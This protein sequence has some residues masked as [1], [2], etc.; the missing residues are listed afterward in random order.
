MNRN[1]G[2]TLIEMLITLLALSIL[3]FIGTGS[4]S[5]MLNKNEREVIID[6]LK[7]A[8]DFARIQSMTKNIALELIPTGSDDWSPGAQLVKIN[9]KSLKEGIH[10]W[11]WGHPHWA[12]SWHGVNSAKKIKF[13][14]DPLQAISNGRFILQNSGT[15]ERVEVVLNRLG[16]LKIEKS[17]VES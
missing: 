2:Y 4:L 7:V 11:Q 16:R 8:V 15:K 6:E 17:V 3:L 1:S 10:E 9:N 5:N 13:S 14:P 12:I